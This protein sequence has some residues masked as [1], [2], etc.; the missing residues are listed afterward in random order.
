MFQW[1]ADCWMFVTRHKHRCALKA[2]TGN[3]PTHWRWWH[4]PWPLDTKLNRPLADHHTAWGFSLGGLSVETLFLPPPT[5]TAHKL[6]QGPVTGS[7]TQAH[8]L[9]K[10]SLLLRDRRMFLS[11]RGWQAH[12]CC[13]FLLLQTQSFCL[14]L[15]VYMCMCIKVWVVFEC[16]YVPVCLW[17]C[18]CLPVSFST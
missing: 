2:T 10:P 1:T 5:L 8:I 11:Y 6:C 4:S 13:R 14:P 16:V 15:C 17:L 18:L 3:S 12:C 9:R 7:D